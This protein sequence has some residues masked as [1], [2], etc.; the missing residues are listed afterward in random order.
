MLRQIKEFFSQKPPEIKTS[1]IPIQTGSYL[2]FVLRGGGYVTASKAMQYY[3][4]NAAI[5][6]AVDNIA[7]SFEQFIPILQD[8]KTGKYDTDNDV[9]KFLKNPNGF[10][11]WKEFAGM[12]SRHY[13]L[14]HD[15]QIAALGNIN[16]PPIEMYAVKP[17]NVNIMEE[18]KDSYPGKY[19]ISSG[20]GKGNYVR[21]EKM[22]KITRF[23]DSNLKELYHIMGFSSRNNNIEGD[24]PLM[25]AALEAQQQI[26]GKTHNLQL[27]NNGGKLSLI[28]A[29]KDNTRITGDQH[30]ERKKRINEDLSGPG[31]AGKIAVISAPEVDIKD[32]GSS[33]KDMD[34]AKLDEISNTAIYLRYRYPL[35]LI[36]AKAAT[37]NNMENAVL[38]L[39]DQAVLPLATVMFG[40]MSKFL[41]PR[42][43][44]DPER[45]V[46]TY[47][48]DDIVPLMTRRLKE[49]SERV[50]FGIET[51]NELRTLLPGRESIGKA[52]DILY[53][54]AALIPIGFDI[55]KDENEGT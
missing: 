3:G 32:V 41:L 51:K 6:T 22:G 34:Y 46:I 43:N 40:G 48:P 11:T 25:A 44:M 28:V 2:D 5:A 31:N 27:L 35:P 23:Y 47:N 9:I 42:F 12:L 30:N 8:V 38:Q 29:F 15:S 18:M 17:Q 14:K 20:V 39:F 33:N 7:G 1:T 19:I 10:E 52:G 4:E 37:Y 36:T 49:I 45:F 53:Q 13:L 24:S 55:S 16:R 54:P 21:Q 26:K 50:K